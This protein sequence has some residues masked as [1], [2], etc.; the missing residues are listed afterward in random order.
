MS[1]LI[2]RRVADGEQV[3]VQ[4]SY[5]DFSIRKALFH[6]LL[7]LPIWGRERGKEG[8]W[9]E[10]FGDRAPTGRSVG[11]WCL[12]FITRFVYRAD[13]GGQVEKR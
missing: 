6:F 10:G 5:H 1:H 4:A 3:N 8:G 13:C 2:G 7:S 9:K 12:L 11:A